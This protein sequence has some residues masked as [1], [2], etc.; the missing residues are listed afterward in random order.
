MSLRLA[1]LAAMLALTAAPALA[2]TL[3]LA[4]CHPLVGA[5]I[6]A[7]GNGD[8]NA[9][10]TTYPDNPGNSAL[11]LA[12]SLEVPVVDGWGSAPTSGRW[13]GR[14]RTAIFAACLSNA[15]MSVSAA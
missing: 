7:S 8:Y 12:A 14:S 1:A 2:Q 13:S 10:R 15:T 3:T 5:A 6:G 9:G 11:D 4:R